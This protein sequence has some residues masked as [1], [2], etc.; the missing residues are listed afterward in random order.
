MIIQE[1]EQVLTFLLLE[2]DD[3]ARELR[4][5]IYRLF[6]CDRMG[7]DDGMD[8]ADRI[9][10]DNS[11]L[12]QSTLC[13]FVPG[14][15][16][17]EA[18]EAF[19]E[20]GGEPFVSFRLVDKESITAGG[21]DVEGIQES[22]PRRLLLIGD[23]TV[24]GNGVGAVIEE[25]SSGLV[26][27]TAVDEVHFGKPSWRSTCG[28]DVQTTEVLAKFES[29]LDWERGKVLITECDYLLLGDEEGQ[30]VFARIGECAE[31]CSPYFGTDG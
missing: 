5:D 21:G 27:G 30:L 2:A 4:I 28:V 24:P 18:E 16:G 9:A 10:A 19:A 11:T 22:C 26:I 25:G 31:L 29:F 14:V 3:V 15:H 23:I 12:C 17:F 1:F 13:L 8:R 6:A 20:C 7:A